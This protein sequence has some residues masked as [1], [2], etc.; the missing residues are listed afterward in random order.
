ME[1]QNNLYVHTY[2]NQNVSPR[3]PDYRGRHSFIHGSVADY[4]TVPIS[5]S[6]WI[7]YHSYMQ[8][9]CCGLHTCDREWFP[10]WLGYLLVALRWNPWRLEQLYSEESGP[11]EEWATSPS[12]SKLAEFLQETLWLWARQPVSHPQFFF[13]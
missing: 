6:S 7:V 5:S 13:H 12:C 2:G 1:L 4:P 11:S 10:Y 8:P 3:L 9:I